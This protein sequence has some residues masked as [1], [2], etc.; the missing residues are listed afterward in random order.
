MRAFIF[1]FAFLVG[2]CGDQARIEAVLAL[3]GDAA[4][5]QVIYTDICA[6]CHGADLSGTDKGPNLLL[7]APRKSDE[8]IIGSLL[9]GPEEMPSFREQFSD[10]QL[11]DTL[12]FL[13]QAAP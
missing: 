9:E 4:A 1:L 3:T 8:G 2:A 5:G 7:I 11:A 12:A 10:Q 6:E 13:R